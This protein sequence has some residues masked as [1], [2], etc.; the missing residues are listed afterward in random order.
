MVFELLEHLRTVNMQLV[1]ECRLN[2]E[3]FRVRLAF[4]CIN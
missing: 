1:H 4:L 3:L 2:L